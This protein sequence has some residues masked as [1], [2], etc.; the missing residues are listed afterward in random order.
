MQFVFV[1]STLLLLGL[2]YLDV[3]R[4]SWICETVNF[5]KYVSNIDDMRYEKMRGDAIKLVER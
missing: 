2:D 5:D 4:A 1:M 3:L